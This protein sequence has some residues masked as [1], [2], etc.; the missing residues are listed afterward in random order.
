MKGQNLEKE[1][2]LKELSKLQQKTEALEKQIKQYKDHFKDLL[3]IKNKNDYLL[4]NT[5]DVFCLH[6]LKGNILE[7]KQA[8]EAVRK[9]EDRFQS[10]FEHS[11][12]AIFIHQKG[13]IETHYIIRVPGGWIYTDRRS[14]EASSGVFVPWRN[15]YYRE[16]DVK[17]ELLE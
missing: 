11:I 3:N 4:Q 17:I 6:D 2:L 8:A 1:Q 14:N 16:N 9:S 12:D 7:T 15:N 13:K 10:L 5:T